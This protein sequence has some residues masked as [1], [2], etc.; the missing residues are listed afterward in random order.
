MDQFN[1]INTYRQFFL[2]ESPN[3]RIVNQPY[4]RCGKNQ[5]QIAKQWHVTFT[6]QG[7]TSDIIFS[8]SVKEERAIDL[9]NH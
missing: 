3:N 7:E 4:R 9:L 8:D 6:D 1:D 5:S 2:Q